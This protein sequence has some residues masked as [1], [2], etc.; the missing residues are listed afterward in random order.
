MQSSASSIPFGKNLTDTLTAT[1]EPLLF[2]VRLWASVCLALF[3]A[4]WLELDNPFWA[5]A[6]AAAVSL[7]QLGASLRKGWF[8][9]IGTVVGA[10]AIVVL[11][12]WF[13]QDRIAF[14]GLLALWIGVCAFAATVLRNFASYSAALAGY[15]AAI[16]AADNLGATGGASSDVFLLAVTRA[17]EICIGIACAGVVLAGTDLGGAQRRLAASFTD[18]TTGIAGQFTRMLALEGP[19]LPDT[20]TERREFVR[21][22]IA[23]DPMIDQAL[24]ESS[25]VRYHSPILQTAVHGLFRAM[26]GWRAVATH[27][28][29]LPDDI[30]R[31][32]VESILRCIPSELRS[33][34]DPGSALRW[35]ADP[36]A[37]WRVCEEAARSLRALP[38]DTPSLRLLADETAKVQDGIL[39]VLDG[40]ALLVETPDRPPARH[41]GFRLSVPDWMPALVNAGRA[42]VAVGA[43]ALFW[44]VTA[45]PSGASAILFAAIVVLLSSPRGELAY[46]NA[47]A[48]TLGATATVLCAAI[49]KF[50][51]LPAFET[52]PAFCLAIGLFLIPAGVAVAQSRLPLVKR[53]FAPSGF[54]FL[55]A[56]G[57]TNQMSYDTTAFYNLALAI[58]VGC[59]VAALAFRLLPSPSPSW[60]SR[61]LLALS[62]RDLRRLAIA[63]VPKTSVDWESR[64]YGRL[65]ALLDEAEPIQRARLLAALSVGA[66]IIELRRMTLRLGVAAEFDAALEAFAR[67]NSGI[68]TV[69][70]RQLDRRLT[71]SSEDGP[72]TVLAVRARSRILIISEAL[73]E[74]AAY[75]D[76]GAL[77]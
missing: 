45:W 30:P 14:L 11:T 56:L 73:T 5:G 65:A 70:L 25:H 23:L 39:D 58:V 40:L 6:S 29:R 61:R 52:F 34:R 63:P 35:M 72:N 10:T 67:G 27:L 49:I 37:L 77:A 42:F 21:R 48:F 33:A 71:S 4:F 1:R 44:L 24:G 3:L 28:G 32:G 20:R 16:I 66:A 62:L 31:R 43:V 68:A 54:F 36:M 47:I 75:F 50:G 9:M 74:H 15:T 51:L 13:P 22:V 59:G 18:L 76:A 7:P 41:R 60:R 2:G 8:R 26:D 12:A 19:Q 46:Y 17:S 69:R 57:P 64:I 55:A 38:A 53:M